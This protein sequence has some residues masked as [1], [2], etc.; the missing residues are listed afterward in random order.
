MMST[1]RAALALAIAGLPLATHGFGAAPGLARWGAPTQGARAARVAPRAAVAAP[2]RTGGD[3]GGGGGGDGGD[4][5]DD[6]VQ[7]PWP[8]RELRVKDYSLMPGEVAVRFIN[9]PGRYPS[10]GTNDIVAAAKPG[11]VLLKVGDSVGGKRQQRRLCELAAWSACAVCLPPPFSPPPPVP[12]LTPPTGMRACDGRARVQWSC[13]AAA[14]QA[15]AGAARAISRSR[16]WAPT[17]ASGP[18]PGRAAPR[19]RSRTAARRWWS[20]CTA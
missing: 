12:R 13:R 8:A 15:S 7:L 2:P 16:S 10:D 6:A 11:E 20:M 18:S 14:S 1:R 17:T 19:W 3:G 9:A 5:R 4:A